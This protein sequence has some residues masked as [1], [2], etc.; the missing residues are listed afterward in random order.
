[1]KQRSFRSR[2]FGANRINGGASLRRGRCF[3]RRVRRPLAARTHD[4]RDLIRTAEVDEE[5]GRYRHRHR[6]GY[7]TRSANYFIIEDSLIR[8]ARY[9]NAPAWII[10][11]H[12]VRTNFAFLWRESLFT[13]VSCVTSDKFLSWNVHFVINFIF[14]RRR[15]PVCNNKTKSSSLK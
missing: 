7:I 6:V 4:R 10:L 15:L 12:L 8:R 1:M 11:A 2:T 3:C 9:R 13:A 5:D 14:P